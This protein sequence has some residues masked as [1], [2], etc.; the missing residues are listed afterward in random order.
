MA[1]SY[2]TFLAGQRL[3]AS[4]LT[5]A[6]PQVARKTA[7]T[8][9]ASTTTFASDP[10]L[11]FSV[12]AN[13][14]YVVDGWIKYF[15]DPTPDIQVKFDAPTGSLGEWHQVA[16]GSSTTTT[17]TVGYS[18]RTDTNDLTVS[19]NFYGV[20]DWDL[21]AVIHAT[22]RVGS[23]AGTFAL[24]WAQSTS[25]ATATIVYTDSWLRLQRIA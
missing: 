11:T 15:A 22:L 3:T 21:G 5:S 17:T 18:V 8:S 16:A 9:R 1:E 23:T 24:Q 4:L 13:A 2:P 12:E 10:H 6:L 7:D 25:S 20:S 14:V 19:R